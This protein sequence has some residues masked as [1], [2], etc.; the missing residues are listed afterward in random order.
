VGLDLSLGELLEGCAALQAGTLSEGALRKLAASCMRIAG[1]DPALSAIEKAN[2][3]ELL[4]GVPRVNGVSFHALQ[5]MRDRLGREYLLRWADQ[6]RT[7]KPY[8]PERAAR[9]V[10]SHLLDS[11]F[12][13]AFLYDWIKSKVG[14]NEPKEWTLAQVCEAAH[15]NL[16]TKQSQDFDVLVAFRSSPRS[17]SGYP[18]HWQTPFAI[19]GWLVDN[20][21][22]ASNIRPSGGLI[23]NVKARDTFGA[24]DVA[25]GLTDGYI[26]RASIATGQILAPLEYVWVRGHPTPFPYR[27]KRR[28]VRVKALY[29]EDQI[30]SGKPKSNVDAAIELLA[31]L[32]NSSPSAAIAGGWA[33][34]E[35]LLS[36]P[37]DRASAADSLASIVACSFP[38]AELTVLSYLAERTNSDLAPQLRACAT[39]RDRAAV[40]AP[41]IARGETLN[42]TS[43]TEEASVRRMQALFANPSATLTAMSVSVADAFHRLYRQR[44]MILHGGVTD[45]I[46]LPHALR[47]SAKLVG[48]G[49]DRVAHGFYVQGA[50]PK[51]IGARAKLA[52][53]LV[54]L[55][56]PIACID[57]LG[58]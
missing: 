44:N 54:P 19:S 57:L 50:S 13:E 29:R 26:A 55:G 43:K 5:Q 7:G 24:A 14:K 10:A 47:T 31:H 35:A 34:I 28:G 39:N 1:K 11:G 41:L 51:E 18:P 6:F 58:E 48:A 16:A 45:S 21:F 36:E 17:A 20:G 53:S 38:R 4:R 37:D 15:E 46:A 33:A 25:I 42:L 3:N 49:I 9:S 40:V 56:D 30:F 12:S 23:L 27:A 32:E 2:L 22:S 8:A 52:I